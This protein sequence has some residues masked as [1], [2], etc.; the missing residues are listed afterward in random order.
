M[1]LLCSESILHTTNSN[2]FIAKAAKDSHRSRLKLADS[3]SVCAMMLLQLRNISL[4]TLLL[5]TSRER[6]FFTE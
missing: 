1:K 3:E 2:C 5:T 6:R 4:P